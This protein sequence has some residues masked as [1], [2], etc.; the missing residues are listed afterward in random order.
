MVPAWWEAGKS[1]RRCMRGQEKSPWAG[2]TWRN[3]MDPRHQRGRGCYQRLN[4]TG[5]AQAPC[6]DTRQS[7]E[8]DPRQPKSG[9]PETENWAIWGSG[10]RTRRF[11]KYH[12]GWFW[13]LGDWVL[14]LLKRKHWSRQ[15]PAGRAAACREL[16]D[17][18]GRNLPLWTIPL[19]S[20]LWFS[21]CKRI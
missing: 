21:S 17:P 5:R 6:C 15:T 11:R 19:F 7:S 8:R 12:K 20:H 14:A 16:T 9:D 4:S 1:R 10:K 3:W 2:K 13:S 18:F